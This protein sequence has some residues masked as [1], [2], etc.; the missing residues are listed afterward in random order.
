ME[1]GVAEQVSIPAL[2]PIL[3]EHGGGPTEEDHAW[4]MF[5]GFRENAVLIEGAEVWGEVSAFLSAFRAAK[6]NW[7]PKLSPNFDW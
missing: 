5:E 4:H 6:R 1:F 7:R 2:C 3:F